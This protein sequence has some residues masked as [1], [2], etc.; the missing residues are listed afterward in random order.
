MVIV[1]GACLLLGFCTRAAALV[2]LPQN[3]K[4]ALAG[5][6]GRN[7]FLLVVE[8]IPVFAPVEPDG[9]EI[10]G[11]LRRMRKCSST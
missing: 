8:T 5:A 6:R 10:D 7:P 4:F 2:G 3:L 9:V 1:S 11:W